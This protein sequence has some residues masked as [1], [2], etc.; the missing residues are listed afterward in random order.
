[1]LIAY[2][3][4]RRRGLAGLARWI[5]GALPAIATAAAA[6]SWAAGRPLHDFHTVAIAPDGRHIA[7]IESDD[8]PDGSESPPRQL[9]I[10]TPGGGARQVML[11]CRSGPDCLPSSPS[12]NRDGSRLAFV[13]SSAGA[14][15]ASIYVV[16][17]GGNAPHRLARFAGA[18]GTLRYGPEDRLAVLATAHPHKKT[19]AVEAA[20]PMAGEIGTQTDEQRIAMLRD[21]ALRMVSP[22][23]LFV[24][25]FDWRPDG[26]G[27]VA[28]A[29]KG[30]GDTQWWVS[31]LVAVAAADGAVSLLHAPDDAHQQ[32]A[33]PV[34]SPDG[35]SVAF[36]GGWMSDFGS[37]GGDAF[38]LKLDQPGAKAVDLTP[39][40]HATVTT[41]DWYCGPGLTATA[42]AG[43]RTDVLALTQAGSARTLWSGEGG[44]G[45]G[46]W[47]LG[48]ACAGGRSAAYHQTFLAPPELEAGPIG[49]WRDL[50]HVN[51][52]LVAP[53]QA[54]SVT[55]K[56]DRFDVQG[57]L[58]SPSPARP[59]RRP[60]LVQVHGG[61]QAAET[62]KFLAPRGT[63]RALLAAGYDLF[64]PNYRGSFGQGEAF[65]AADIGDFGG[66]DFRDIMA[67]LDA[68]ERS[69]P[70]DD[71]RLGIFGGSYGG[72][73]SMWAVTQT[74]RFGA[75]ASHAGISN[76]LSEQ[77]EAPQMTADAPDPVFGTLVYDDPR[78]Q[79]H[80]S[81]ITHMRGVR[82]PVLI[83]V[84][85]RDVECP[86]PQSQEF[87]QA[88]LTLG[89]PTS[90][91]VYAGEGHGFRNEAD[92]ADER[93][94][95]VAWFDKWLVARAGAERNLAPGVKTAQTGSTSMVQDSGSKGLDKTTANTP[96]SGTDPGGTRPAPTSGKP[97][98][99]PEVQSGDQNTN[100]PHGTDRK[101]P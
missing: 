27:F 86:L 84:G 2:E 1:M 19:G 23:D 96:I 22:A 7:S 36:I 94:R 28:T 14:A 78:P 4:C 95:T 51:A 55:W 53:V 74:H 67:G 32:L 56:S 81:P 13:I 69:V 68:V 85:E 40:L 52:G 82:T 65:V 100:P 92:R 93:R 10:R 34:V 31:K 20:A 62:P 44:I 26:A 6:P 42:L 88:L 79:L 66:G 8:V 98:A 45:A 5:W 11:P 12:W 38:L 83:T 50:T 37:N 76:W 3:N 59:G 60:L 18:L 63:D 46:G 101:E 21:G 99:R 47:N 97:A 71:G 24:Y 48:L 77:G 70:I 64:L 16:G 41:L 17:A 54:R 80:A 91:V 15:S 39:G 61:P 25:E 89:V 75:A 29:A 73:M 9:F 58:L 43:A 72:Y 33:D 90:F 49:R 87:Y 35:R 30:D 57:W